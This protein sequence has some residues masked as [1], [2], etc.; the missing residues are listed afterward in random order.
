MAV[1]RDGQGKRPDPE[2]ENFV[3]DIE[4]EASEELSVD[5]KAEEAKAEADDDDVEDRRL[6]QN[7]EDDD[8]DADDD[9]D[10]GRRK[11]TVEERRA[12]R[13]ADRQRMRKYR[14]Q[15]VLEAAQNRELLER[16]LAEN[17]RLQEQLGQVQERFRIDDA[18]SIEMHARRAV[19]DVTRAEAAYKK[20]VEEMDGE[21]AVRA[22]RLRDDALA[23]LHQARNA[24][25]DMD[26]REQQARQ[27]AQQPQVDPRIQQ[28]GVAWM[29]ANSDWFDPQGNDEESIIALAIDRA[30]TAEGKDPT[31]KQYWEE[32]DRRVRK[33]LPHVF[34]GEDVDDD[35]EPEKPR[36]KARS[37]QAPPVGGRGDTSMAASKRGGVKV[38]ITP[39][40]KQALIDLGVWGD[41][42]AMKPYLKRYA[43]YDR[44][45]RG[46]N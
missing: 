28:H 42:E 23:R 21:T 31:T 33:R 19:D 1:N 37:R 3:L 8:D 5:K 36:Q 14:K 18:Q 45:Q 40:R 11:E 30:M 41:Q 46:Q 38:T 43:D 2:E 13:K 7:D 35:D 17:Q 12:R 27:Q 24:K 20:A 26:R 32:L 10:G 16:V 34:E 39:E 22:Q 9:G 4:D 6:A 29:K 25:A 44:A 15:K